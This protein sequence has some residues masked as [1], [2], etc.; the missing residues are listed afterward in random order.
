MS[1]ANMP[2]YQVK[3]TLQGV[4]LPIWRRLLVPSDRTLAQ[5][6]H[7]IQAAM[8][9]TNSHMYLFR[10][11][12]VSFVDPHDSSALLEM[13]AIDARKV[14]LGHIIPLRRPFRG[15]FR[16]VI[17]YEYDFG[18]SWLHEVLFEDVLPPDPARKTPVCTEGARACP[19]EDVGGVWGYQEFVT[20]IN[21][22]DHPEHDEYME[23]IDEGSFDPEAFDLDAVN[24]RLKGL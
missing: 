4:E 1:K 21:D 8:G 24:A 3:I 16:H 23:W 20:A 18:D 11:G 7:L 10:L 5:F 12:P 13:T 19:P 14:K 22:P 15:E 9:W 2:I 6:H 17:E